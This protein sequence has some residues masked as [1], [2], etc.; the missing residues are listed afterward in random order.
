[1]ETERS[2]EDFEPPHQRLLEAAERFWPWLFLL[3][4]LA[5]FSSP[6]AASSTRST[7][8]ASAPMLDRHDHGAPPDL[9]H[10]RRWHRPVGGL[11]DGS[12]VGRLSHGDGP[13]GHLVPLAVVV[14]AGLAGGLI[15]GP[16]TGL[17]TTLVARVSQGAAVHR[18]A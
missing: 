6:A 7:S 8:S 12:V 9:R 11:R 1:V 10:H 13:P 14:L 3:A 2:F 15:A 17:V 4:L 5:V 16:A 18:H